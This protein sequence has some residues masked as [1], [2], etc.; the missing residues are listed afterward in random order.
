MPHAKNESKRSQTAKLYSEGQGSRVIASILKENPTTTYR[1]LVRMGLIRN[2]EEAKD[3]AC[4]T[5]VLHLPFSKSSSSQNLRR[6]AVGEAIR[7]FLSRGYAPS[8]PVE[9]TR[10][11]L[12]VESDHGLLKVQ[13]KSTT[14][15]Q[16]GFWCVQLCRLQYNSTLVATG[17]A[18]KRRRQSYL[19][20]EVDLFFIYTSD[21]SRYLIPL[22]AIGD[23]FQVS[24]NQKFDKYKV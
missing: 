18:G 1:R 21:G 10:Y 19:K 14:R 7:W 9:P 22:E 2:R 6:S 8:I 4:K 3:I 13:I 5:Q 17:S 12:I 11:D 16:N 15:V 20:D 23:N 24:L